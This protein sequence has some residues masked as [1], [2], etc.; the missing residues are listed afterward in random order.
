MAQTKNNKL[1]ARL[2]KSTVIDTVICWH[3]VLK[4]TLMWVYNLVQLSLKIETDK[5]NT[6]VF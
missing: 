4:Q 5:L 1:K 6:E 3:D 2:T